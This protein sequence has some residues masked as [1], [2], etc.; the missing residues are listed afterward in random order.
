MRNHLFS[1]LILN[2]T[3]SLPNVNALHTR[4]KTTSGRGRSAITAQ[5]ENS[6][7]S[8]QRWQKSKWEITNFSDIRIASWK[9]QLDSF[10][11]PTSSA[12]HCRYAGTR[13]QHCKLI[14][15]KYERQQKSNISNQSHRRVGCWTVMPQR[16]ANQTPI[17]VLRSRHG[18]AQQHPYTTPEKKKS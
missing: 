7:S 13:L 1:F 16:C 12:L 9:N 5:T 3:V 2:F 14:K 17:H 11:V 18:T 4:T 15:P 6:H 10:S 8:L